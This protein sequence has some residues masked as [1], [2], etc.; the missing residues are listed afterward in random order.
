[1]SKRQRLAWS[2]TIF[3]IYLLK[4]WLLWFSFSI[5]MSFFIYINLIKLNRLNYLTVRNAGNIFR[6]WYLPLSQYQGK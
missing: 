5:S 1:M 6:M 2:V 4:N 3:Q